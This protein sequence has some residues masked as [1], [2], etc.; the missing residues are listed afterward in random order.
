MLGPYTDPPK[1]A[2]MPILDWEVLGRWV[3]VKVTG[4]GEPTRWGCLYKSIPTTGAE[5]LIGS[6]QDI[7]EQDNA[8]LRQLH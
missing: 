5:Y 6:Q 2:Q 1:N 7:G 3:D 8:E 4:G